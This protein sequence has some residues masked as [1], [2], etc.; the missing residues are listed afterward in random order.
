[1][2]LLLAHNASLQTNNVQTEALH[3]AALEGPSSIILHLS[4]HPNFNADVQ[5][6]T[7]LTPLHLA[8]IAERGPDVIKALL[9]VGADVQGGCDDASL[10]SCTPLYY[11]FVLGELEAAVLLLQ[12]GAKP[13][14]RNDKDRKKVAPFRQQ[15]RR[16]QRHFGESLLANTLRKENTT[17]SSGRH[18]ILQRKVMRALLD[19]GC[20]INGELILS[21]EGRTLL[22]LA[23]RHSSSANVRFLLERGAEVN[24]KHGGSSALYYA[25]SERAAGSL[26]EKVNKVTTLLEHGADLLDDNVI[27][28]LIILRNSKAVV[29]AVADSLGPEN[30]TDSHKIPRVL[31]I[32]CIFQ[33]RRIYE[34]I[35][36]Y[37]GV[38]ARATDEDIRHALER[39]AHSKRNCV[40]ASLDEMLPI[41]DEMRPGLTV[42]FLLDQWRGM[43]SH[44]LVEWL[45]QIKGPDSS[46]GGS[47]R[48][49][50]G[51]A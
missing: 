24:A 22:T 18:G 28:V 23:V 44:Y 41:L 37:A 30:L 4:T 20:D 14:N 2:K 21:N 29:D 10:Y 15:L 11:A 45:E 34:S 40:P 17:G 25:L 35:K 6:R 26:T 27:W 19:F 38:Q 50:D 13:F 49:D 9:D 7:R 47:S 31:G 5:D 43:M 51:Q 12:A 33:E 39:A 16:L 32:C 1:M 48:S 42:D 46:E 3:T 36:T 8:L